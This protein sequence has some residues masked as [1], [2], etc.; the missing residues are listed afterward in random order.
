MQVYTRL[1]LQK[2]LPLFHALP[3]NLQAKA[4]SYHSEVISLLDYE[5]IVARHATDMAS[6][7]LATS[8]FL[9]HHAWLGTA[10]FTDDARNRIENAPLME[11][12]YSPQQ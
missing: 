7:Q 12:V 3:D 1:L 4:T 2:F 6:K 11:K 10:T 8:V 5:I 9:H